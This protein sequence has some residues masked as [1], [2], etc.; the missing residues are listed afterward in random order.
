MLSGIFFKIFRFSIRAYQFLFLNA[1]NGKPNIFIIVFR[2]KESNKRIKPLSVRWVCFGFYKILNKDTTERKVLNLNNKESTGG[3]SFF[4]SSKSKLRGF[5]T[6]YKYRYLPIVCT[7]RNN[8][9]SNDPCRFLIL[10]TKH[11]NN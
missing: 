9:I 2:I 8:P 4:L 5:K 6:L 1:L 7:N 10:Q 3:V 11:Y